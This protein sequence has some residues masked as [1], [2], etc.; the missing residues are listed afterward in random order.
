MS[1]LKAVIKL[2]DLY[3]VCF[4]TSR[5][6]CS[7]LVM[8]LVNELKYQTYCTQKHYHFL[9]KSCEDFLKQFPTFFQQKI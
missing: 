1:L 2:Q 8:S 5:P 4:K 6:R 3:V 9:P 7:K